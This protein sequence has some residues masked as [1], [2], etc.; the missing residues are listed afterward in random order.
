MNHPSS[1]LATPQ[2]WSISEP[3]VEKM[4]ACAKAHAH[5]FATYNHEAKFDLRVTDGG[6]VEKVELRSSTF[7]HD[8]L[9]S[10]LTQALAAVSVPSSVL[11]LRSS[12]LISGGE[13]SPESRKQVGVALVVGGAIAAGPVILIAADVTIA[14]YVA[15]VATDAAIEA[16]KRRRQIDLACDP[17]FH[18]CLS[19]PNQPDWNI[20]DFGTGKDC[21]GCLGE[22]RLEKG[23]WP[24]YKCPRPNYRPN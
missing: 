14:V 3:V 12:G 13:S 11:A 4:Q 8:A 19:Y 15:A 9:E 16:A 7:H 2:G 17:L 22:C 20:G 24:N 5:E 10:C 1:G 6:D 18:E 23:I 21:L